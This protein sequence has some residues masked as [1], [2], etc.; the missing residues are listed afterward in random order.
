M[1]RRKLSLAPNEARLGAALDRVV[2]RT[3]Q[4][5]GHRLRLALERKRLERLDVDTTPKKRERLFPDE[6]LS[7][8]RR[9]L[10]AGGDIDGITGG[11]A[12]LCAGDDLARG[13]SDAALDDEL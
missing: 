4:E 5:G 12:L 6:R 2:H 1:D 9:L 8:L 7:R 13:D 11:E 3:Q 10:Q